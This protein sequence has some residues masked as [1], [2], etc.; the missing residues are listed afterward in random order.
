M[1]RYEELQKWNKELLDR[2]QQQALNRYMDRTEQREYT[3]Q[4]LKTR[5][6]LEVD[7]PD[8]VA[9]RESMLQGNNLAMERIIGRNDLFP[10]AYFQAGLQA[11][12]SVC[13]IEVRDSIGR[14]KGHGTGFLISPSVLITN[15]HVLG[16]EEAANDSVA[17]FNYEKDLDGREREIKNFRFEPEQLFMTDKELDFTLVAVEGRSAEGDK[18]TENSYLPLEQRTGKGLVGE[19]VSIIQHPSGS[20]KAVTIRENK[21]QDVFDDFI[22]YSTDTMP[23]SSGSPVFNDEWQVISLH[24]AGVPDPN[25][26]STFIANEGIRIS[27]I[28]EYIKNHRSQVSDQAQKL[29]DDIVGVEQSHDDHKA[30]DEVPVE[31]LSLEWYEGTQGYNS[32][33]LGDDY[34]IPHP[35]FCEEKQKDIAPLKDGGHIL[36]Y[37]HFSIVMSKSRRLAFYSVVNIDGKNLRSVERADKWYLDP[38]INKAYQAGQDLYYDNPLDRGHIVRRIDPVWGKDAEAANEDTFHFTNCAP[39]HKDLNQQTWLDLENYIVENARNHDMKATVFTGPVFR[40]D[41]RIYRSVQIPV[42][43][44]KI[45]VM[46]K[47]DGNLSATAYLQSQKNL[48]ENLEFAY[49]DY[50]TYQVPVQQIEALTGL[51]F[52]NLRNHD[53][54]RGLESTIG[55]IIEGEDD[56]TV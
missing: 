26:P 6:P 41:D 39:Q 22:H 35:T 4:E 47:E 37:T 28:V 30:E 46:V 17:Q 12:K 42:E 51:T 56:I 24:H 9:S 3:E 52:G 25:D 27:S 34:E 13:R 19:R 36:N 54:I 44:W 32:T 55:H 31:E 50:K 10:I 11:A 48:V 49:G 21:I 45:A 16:D 14:V 33:F 5:N 7:S 2:Q 23:G 20:P 53:P 43:F 38:R 8:R 15:H 1:L 29:V 18:L 40:S